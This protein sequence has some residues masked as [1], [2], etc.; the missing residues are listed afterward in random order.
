MVNYIDLGL[1]SGLLWADENEEGLLTFDEAKERYGEQLPT[2]DE[3]KELISNCKWEWDDEKKGMKVI[4]PNRKSIFLPTMGLRYGATPY[5]AGTYGYYWSS[6]LNAGSPSDAYGVGFNSDTVLWYYDY[7]CYG[8]SVRL[9]KRPTE[10]AKTCRHRTIR[11]DALDDYAK[12]VISWEEEHPDWDRQVIR[13][14]AYHFY[15]FREK[16]IK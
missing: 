3:W 13:A 1:P 10:K 2:I 12:E 9:V 6:S 4:G 11:G 14:T 7:R 5:F 15:K 8:L 16:F